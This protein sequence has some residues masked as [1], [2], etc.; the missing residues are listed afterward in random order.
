MNLKKIPWEYKDEGNLKIIW[1]SL[2]IFIKSK[3]CVGKKSFVSIFPSVGTD[4][5]VLLSFKIYR[6]KNS[7]RGIIS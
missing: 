3:E 7:E 5:G 1:N 6:I 4:V 2:G